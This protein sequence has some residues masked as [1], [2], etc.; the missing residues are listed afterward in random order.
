MATEQST[1]LCWML[2]P[3]QLGDS[4]ALR[5]I[6][7]DNGFLS[8]YDVIRWITDQD[9]NA[10][11]MIWRRLLEIHPNMA[12]L[13]TSIK[14]TPK[15]RGR[16]AE[17]PATDAAGIVQ[18]IMVLPGRA[19]DKFRQAASGVIVRYLGGDPG[20]V[21]E[22]WANR[23]YQEELAASQPEHPAR[24]FGEAAEAEALAGAATQ[25]QEQQ[26]AE[27]QIALVRAQTKK[28]D[29]ET[30]LV[31]LQCVALAQQMC[32]QLGF[33]FQTNSK[34]ESMARARCFRL[35]RAGMEAWTPPST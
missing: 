4:L 14:F 2:T 17:T 21:Q 1:E 5:R 15:G 25:W 11:R 8:V 35:G 3:E 28:A 27:A 7:A 16:P 30:K 10:C 34:Y 26:L 13:C 19:A 32:S 22:I 20:L 6:R 12:T 29:Q 31:T 9:L 24:V 23:R 18:I 33:G